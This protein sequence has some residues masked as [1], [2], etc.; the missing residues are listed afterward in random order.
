MKHPLATM[1]ANTNKCYNQINHIVMSLLL[2][3][4]VGSIGS[5]MAI[6]FPIQTMNFFQRTARGDSTTFMGGRGKDNPLQGLCQGNGASPACW[7]MISSVLMHCY[8]QQGF[9][10]RII[11]PISGT[12][13]DFL[14]ERYV[15]DMDLIITQPEF[16]TAQE[17]QEGLWDAA[18]AWASGLNATGSA[19][20][21][22][23]SCWIYAG[24]EWMN[25]NWRYAK[26]PN[27]PMEIPLPDRSPAMISQAEVSTAEKALGVWSTVDGNDTEHLSKN[28]AGR[29][30][31]WTSKMTNGHLPAQLGWIT[32]KFK[33]WPGIRYGLATPATPFS[34]AQATLQKENFHILPFMGI[35]QNVKWE[36]RTLHRAFGGIGLFDLAVEHT[37]GMINIFIQHYGAGTTVAMKYLASLEILQLEIGYC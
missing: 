4:I 14:R 7:L 32:Y 28:V 33:L 21:P 5:V 1:S 31:K 35:N 22:E 37:I 11:S 19:I 2:L 34:T 17:T 9:G 3:A 29:F 18:W 26:Q 13:I 15:D 10:L 20:N 8:K 36:W 25:G 24:Y 6:L 12:I 27:L 23:K 16:T 30:M